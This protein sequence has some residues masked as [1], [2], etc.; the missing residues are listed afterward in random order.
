MKTI[1]PTKLSFSDHT[2]L[3]IDDNTYNVAV[4][5]NYLEEQGAKVYVATD[6]KL[7]L[8]V[9]QRTQ[10]DLIILDVMMP[11]MD[12]FET[13][14]RLKANPVTKEIPIIFMTA[15]TDLD[16]KVAGFETGAVDY[17]TKPVQQ[18]EVLARIT[19]HL[20]LHQLTQSLSK[21][22][23]QLEIGSQIGQ[24]LNS[25]LNLDELLKQIVNLLQTKFD[26]YHVQIYLL[27]EVS[28]QLEMAEGSGSIGVLLK[29]QT[30]RIAITETS[31]VAR[32]ARSGE[33]MIVADVRQA[34]DWLPNPLLPKTRSEIAI[35]ITMKDQVIGILD[36]QSDKVADWDENDADLLRLL[37]NQVA[38][39][40][41]NARLFEETT[42]AR[43]NAEVANQT[44]STFLAN[45]SHELRTPL[46]GIL[47]YAQILKR[48]DGLTSRQLDGLDIIQQSGD[49][50]L[51]LINDVLDLSKIE[52]GRIDIHSATIHFSSFLESIAGI[53]RM[54][55]QQKS[56]TF[57]YNIQPDLP[58]GIKADETRL[59]Q[60]LI[61][62][63]GNA[64]KFTD[65]GEVSFKVSNVDYQAARE[66][67]REAEGQSS[68][69]NQN[70][71][72]R[73]EVTDTG[74][75]ISSEQVKKIFL[76]FEQVGDRQRQAAGTGLGLAISQQLV[77]AMGGKLQVKSQ[78]GKGSTFW[79][80]IELPTAEL[81]NDHQTTRVDKIVGYKAEGDQRLKVLVVDDKAY[82]RSVLLHFLEPLGFEVVE[83]ENGQQGIEQAQA[84]RPDLIVIDMVMPVM[85]GFEA[86]QT[87]RQMSAL[88]DV[89]IIAASASV[90]E[91][92]KQSSLTIGCD[93]FI[94]K[95][96]NIP[97]LFKLMEYHLPLEWV[98]EQNDD[99]LFSE[100]GMVNDESNS[101]I[102]PSELIPPP[103]EEMEILLDLAMKGY[104]LNIR[105]RATQ[106][107][108]MDE[109]YKPFALKLQQ[110]AKSFED[111]KIMA[112][113]KQFM[114][115]D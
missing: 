87:I 41:T 51:T 112:L 55:A 54:R 82:H 86:V 34:T 65:N 18:E 32:V 115:E 23:A 29:E 74:V 79:F 81:D 61:N 102:H 58:I 113:I 42:Q 77:Q 49:H 71:L 14:R 25:I 59:R 107:E 43:E 95:P 92:D 35:P 44:K 111:D 24:Q 96:I 106:I 89:V 85:M 13:C 5:V 84:I 105:T 97:Q 60:V 30:H 45:M 19:T 109:K 27:N 101:N 83:A 52:A 99:T 62:L 73:F 103:P 70:Q 68:N 3:V 46:N 53:I 21:R 7:G 6:G 66:N 2:L 110:L 36:V 4:M 75:G 64:I 56:I 37:A 40:L 72:V 20:R 94:P 91:T 31:L 9:A 80:E 11:E 98:Y 10:P 48:E 104:I 26:Y 76:P 28:Q 17:V 78:V 47:G 22:T 8:K 100:A 90:F 16:S 57:T 1:R 39:A 108:Q 67:G 50:L 69:P 88:R 63:L 93:A 33:A 12:G 38:V 114:P 15:L